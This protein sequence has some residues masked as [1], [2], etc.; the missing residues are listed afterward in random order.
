MSEEMNAAEYAAENALRGLARR[1]VCLTGADIARLVREARQEARRAKRSLAW[2]DLEER[3]SPS[4]L[5]KPESLRWR[6]AVHEAGHAVARRVLNLGSVTLITISG[7][8]GDGMVVSEGTSPVAETEEHLSA[9][10]MAMLAGRAAEEEILGTVGAG[11][12]GGTS[13]DLGRAT[14]LALQM[15]TSFGF[16]SATPLLH[17]DTQRRV[18]VL[19]Y[20][21]DI[22]GRVNARLE[23]A[24]A[25]ARRLVKGRE[26]LTRTLALELMRHDTLEGRDLDRLIGRSCNPNG[27]SA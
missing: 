12:G 21:A 4:K 23:T 20:R 7:P 10:L 11:S 6:I 15:E 8:H 5:S 2:T 9:M 14:Q 19:F 17:L 22:A 18:D 26:R 1:A 25:A 27:A 3:L 16:G 24:Y 13:S